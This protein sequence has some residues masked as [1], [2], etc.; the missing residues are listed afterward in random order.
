MCSTATPA[1][2]R[3]VAR[4]R[5]E[6]AMAFLESGLT[7][8]SGA[9]A[10]GAAAAANGA[11]AAGAKGSDA[12]PQQLEQMRAFVGYNLAVVAAE[13]G[14][15]AP[16]LRHAHAALAAADR[17]GEGFRAGN[18]CAGMRHS[19]QCGWR[20][21]G[22][23]WVGLLAPVADWDGRDAAVRSG[24]RTAA[25]AGAGCAGSATPVCRI[26]VEP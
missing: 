22:P 18:G 17:C 20:V 21:V 19:D 16:A 25:G 7:Q 4:V 6:A 3:C 9:A 14:L 5:R 10:A 24:A 13:L 26:L 12:P 15:L 23:R 11:A 2:W 1:P 8:C